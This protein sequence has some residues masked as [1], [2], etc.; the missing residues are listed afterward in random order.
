MKYLSGLIWWQ[1]AACFRGVKCEDFIFSNQEQ[2]QRFLD[3]SEENKELCT[4]ETYSA[5]QG[6]ILDNLH[7]NIWGAS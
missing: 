5:I 7:Y 2:L 1:S 4:P 3:L 6:A